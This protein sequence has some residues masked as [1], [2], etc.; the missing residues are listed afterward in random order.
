VTAGA[1][2]RNKVNGLM[3]G[4]TVLPRFISTLIEKAQING[5][6]GQ[7]VSMM[8]ASEPYQR[9]NSGGG[10]CFLRRLTA[11]RS[12]H[13]QGKIRSILMV[14]VVPEAAPFV[15]IGA[16]TVKNCTLCLAGFKPAD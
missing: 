11:C 8:K 2:R 10:V 4:G 6:S 3:P 15:A 16:T 9:D 13:V 5:S 1:E 7:I 14:Q 12:L